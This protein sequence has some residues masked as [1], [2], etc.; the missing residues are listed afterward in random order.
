MR[1]RLFGQIAVDHA[2]SSGVRAL[3]ASKSR[4]I[5]A[6]LATS[7]P[8]PVPEGRLSE[9][10]WRHDPPRSARTALQTHVSSLRD[11]L[12]PARPRRDPGRFIVSTPGG[13]ALR[14]DPDDLDLTR[15][16]RLIASAR[17]AAE[18]GDADKAIARLNE[19]LEL[20]RPPL[21]DDLALE[22][23]AVPVVTRVEDQRGAAFESR[24]GLALDLAETVADTD[25]MQRA[26]GEF[27]YRERLAGQL[28]LAHYRRGDQHQALAV[29]ADVR[30]RL[31][32]DMGLDVGRE[33]RLL[34]HAILTQDASLKFLGTERPREP[35]RPTRPT[36]APMLGRDADLAA[37]VAA[38][39]RH[40]LVTV[41]GPSGSGKSTLA[42]HVAAACASDFAGRVHTVDLTDAADQDVLRAFATRLR[43][44]DH[45]LVPLVNNLVDAIGVEPVLLVVETCEIAIEPVGRAVAA[46]LAAPG[47]KVLATSQ[48]PLRLRSEHL[49]RLRPLDL[50]S[51]VAILTGAEP[52]VTDGDVDSGRPD[53]GERLQAAAERLDRLPLALELAAPRL[54]ALGVDEL[55]RIID[56]GGELAWESADRP[57]RHRSLD[58][59][60]GWSLD[61]LDDLQF[62]LLSR[63]L[64]HAA[65]FTARATSM[66]WNSPP[67]DDATVSAALA[68][69]VD[70]SLVSRIPGS[71]PRFRLLDGVRRVVAARATPDVVDAAGSCLADAAFAALQSETNG[72]DIAHGLADLADEVLPAAKRLVANSDDR[73]LYLAAILGTFAI[74]RGHIGEV[75]QIMER[76]L[77][78]HRDAPPPV[79]GMVLAHAGFLAWYQGDLHGVRTTLRRIHL[80][81]VEPGFDLV[82]PAVDGCAAFVERRYDDAQ[83]G[84]EAALEMLAP[85]PTATP[86]KPFM[87]L[88]HLTGNAALYAGDLDAAASHYRSH[89]EAAETLDDGF[90]LAQA[91]RFEAVVRSHVGDHETALRWAE[92]SLALA[93]E[94]ADPVGVAQSHAVGAMLAGAAG[95]RSEASVHAVAALDASRAQLDVFALR[96]ALPIAAAQARRSDGDE[97]A[98]RLLGWYLDLLDRSGHAHWPT[99]AR[100]V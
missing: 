34:E 71:E 99:V 59:A 91:L 37:V 66:L 20:S 46:L 9:A 74:E 93:R 97:R 94:D 78:A 3:R 61:R 55:E 65:P 21:L 76:A 54:A 57:G 72:T 69:L 31:R 45:P 30:K 13:Y 11:L 80:L 5:L 64:A 23:W 79:R 26:V 85:T 88:A 44:V 40:R 7:H 22:P 32:E 4:T 50:D 1:V 14:I 47:L 36:T 84:L 27:P 12:E 33:L 17:S 6:V 35:I 29:L 100:L 98:A 41:T 2:D 75:R 81:S 95:F 67:L 16:A 52:G 87:L 38:V 42:A 56:T 83:A 73:S 25:A 48:T 53:I 82:R 19:A 43:V 8:D 90:H 24:F 77:D 62:T 70:R 60:I 86:T 28:A 18:R 92:R 96:A 49:H 89:R 15:F 58:T 39:G 51:A 68:E 10:L 63:L